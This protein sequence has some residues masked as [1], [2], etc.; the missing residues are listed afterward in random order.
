MDNSEILY[1]QSTLSLAS[2]ANLQKGAPKIDALKHAGLTETRAKDFAS[3]WSVVD[4][5]AD[6]S[7]VAATVFQENATGKRYSRRECG[8]PQL[9]N[10]PDK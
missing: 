10:S 9:F 8:H 5:Y 4:T 6:V 1:V 7:G 2:Y 3:N